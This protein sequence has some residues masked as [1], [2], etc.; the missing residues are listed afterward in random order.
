M[1]HLA[2]PLSPRIQYGALLLACMASPASASPILDSP[3]LASFEKFAPYTG[4]AELGTSVS[5]SGVVVWRRLA[6]RLRGGLLPDCCCIVA[7]PTGTRRLRRLI[8]T[9]CKG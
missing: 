8:P 9:E 7:S 1:R 4:S 6:L 3:I 5:A 2:S